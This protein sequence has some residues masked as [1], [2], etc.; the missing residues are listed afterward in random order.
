MIETA[1]R[2]RAAGDWAGACAAADV[3]VAFALRAVRHRWG[4]A[5]ASR[6]RADLRSLAPDLLRWHFPR[7]GPDGLLRAGTAVTL[8]RYEAGTGRPVHLLAGTPPA[9][10]RAGQRLTLW[11][12]DRPG[13]DRPSPDRRFRLDLHRHLWDAG[14]SGE[15]R[16]RAGAPLTGQPP[17][18]HTL[19]GSGSGSYAYGRW[20]AEAALLLR[21]EGHGGTGHVLVRLARAR[22]LLLRLRDGTVTAAAEVRARSR[23]G[24]PVLPDAAVRVPPDVE[25]LR[26]GLLT[27][28]AL[29]PLV[30]E[31]LAPGS[32]RHVPREPREPGVLRIACR[33]GTHRLQRSCAG[34]PFVALDH[35][36][37]ELAREELLTML[38]G[39][40]LPCLAAL[41]EARRSL[42]VHPEVRALLRYGDTA[43]A[44]ALV[45]DRVGPQHE[46]PDGE[47]RTAL[48]EAGRERLRHALHRA[49]LTPAQRVP[50]PPAPR[51][52]RSTR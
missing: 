5:L 28:D 37:E 10:A 31:A 6:L 26:A 24:V 35:S 23:P 14:R 18:W 50:L 32:P 12:G 2:R 40:P 46:L 21:A 33:G 51:R 13:P 45:T 36:R 47:L 48:E 29:H 20:G 42:D 34:G 27:P 3:D 11:L 19:L 16:E 15:L 4:E 22:R 30:A 25:L 7:T 39:P 43:G 49:G 38:G 9:S 1:T 52:P 17:P 41:R 44:T 8:A